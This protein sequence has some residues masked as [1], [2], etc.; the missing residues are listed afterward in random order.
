LIHVE[1]RSVEYTGDDPL[2]AVISL[3]IHRRQLTPSQLA[4]VG[5]ELADHRAKEAERSKAEKLKTS[6][7]KRSRDAFGKLG[8]GSSLIPQLVGGLGRNTESARQ[9]AKA[10]GVNHDYVSRAKRIARVAP[11][12]LNW[13][14]SGKLGLK[15][16]TVLAKLPAL[17]REQVLLDV[18]IAQNVKKA[19][20]KVRTNSLVS[21]PNSPPKDRWCSTVELE[22][23]RKC[24]NEVLNGYVDHANG[25]FESLV[26]CVNELKKVVERV[27]EC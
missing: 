5:L 11:E 21:D 26:E 22:R 2:A 7:S 24:F 3:N 14:K 18:E 25:D 27:T 23:L 6:A 16:A 12:L 10:L 4:I 1:C 9:A 15:D 20:E 13:V 17:Q 19:I 8:S